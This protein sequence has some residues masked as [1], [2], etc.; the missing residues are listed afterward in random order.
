MNF[1]SVDDTSQCVVFKQQLYTSVIRVILISSIIPASCSAGQMLLHRHLVDEPEIDL[2]IL[3]TEPQ[4]KGLQKLLRRLLCS[5][6]R[7]KLHRLYQDILASW[8]GGWI[9]DELSIPE[10]NETAT[11]V[12]TVAHGDAYHAAMRYARRHNLPLVTFFHDWW[13]DIANV[14]KPFRS[15]LEKSFRRLYQ[16]S[17]LALC[18]SSGMQAELGSHANA[19]VLLPI[20]AAAPSISGRAI[21]EAGKPF[22]L[23]YA[24]NLREYGPMLMAALEALKDHPHIRL[25]VRG[26]SS[27]WPDVVK[28][29]MRDTGVLLPF[30]P[31]DELDDW[32]ESAD[33]FLIPQTFNESE[34]RLM[35]TNFPSKLPE[36]SQFCKPL[37]V[38]GPGSASG[39]RWGRETGQAVVL[40]NRDPESLKKVLEELCL[41]KTKQQKFTEAA[42][43]AA[44]GCFDPE[45]IQAQFLKRLRAVSV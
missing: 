1:S 29:V 35:N 43:E 4:K 27:G 15:I 11:V 25:E 34:R 39:L 9:D 18:V 13:P 10:T 2:H 36:V 3:P 19:E 24:G 42:A 23:L 8:H 17:S 38:W 20:P 16:Q 6:E 44:S 5:L 7:L 45:H 28:K 32:L 40:E 37:I 14:H 26:N 31:R 41:D 21:R 33:A 22:K 12:M 30:V